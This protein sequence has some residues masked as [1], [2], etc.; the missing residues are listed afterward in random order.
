MEKQLQ[1]LLLKV[2]EW[3]NKFNSKQK[4]III[5]IGAGVIL[6]LA[7]LVTVLSKPQYTELASCESTKEA[8]TIVDLLE[9]VPGLSTE[10]VTVKLLQNIR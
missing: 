7:I 8:A 6:T 9:G 2:K 1:Q 10:R 4:T 3:W 5:S